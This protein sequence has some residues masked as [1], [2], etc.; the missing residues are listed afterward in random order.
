MPAKH[1][2]DKPGSTTTIT[3]PT[4]ISRQP[5]NARHVL[6]QIPFGVI[7]QYLWKNLAINPRLRGAAQSTG[8][9]ST[10]DSTS[11]R[12]YP[13]MA[14]AGTKAVG[15]AAWIAAE[16]ENVARLLEQE[17]EE[18]E[19]PVRHEMDWLN[20]HMA[21]IFS[22]NQLWVAAIFLWSLDLVC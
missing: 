16:K 21:E 8:I 4:I 9:P 10:L 5:S 2:R 7:L 14:A 6:S 3:T 12:D 11:T 20:E 1:N 22:T 13:A 15:S 17:M 18:V 19:Y